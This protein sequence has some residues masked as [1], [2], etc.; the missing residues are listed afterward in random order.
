MQEN[1]ERRSAAVPPKTSADTG[2][3]QVNIN[4]KAFFHSGDAQMPL[5]WFLRDV[6]R[7]TGTKYGCDTAICGACTVLVDGKSARACEVTMLAAAGREVTTIEGL[8]REELHPVQRAW[9]DAD[10]PLCGYCD[11]GQIMAVVDLLRRKP[12]PSDDDIASISNICRCGTY[13]RIRR[14]I[15]R[16]AELTKAKRK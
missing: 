1:P 15:R 12:N 6:L 5:L 3:L 7:L 10:V 14:A 2:S 8:E 4:G 11:S 13:P 9:I 16:A